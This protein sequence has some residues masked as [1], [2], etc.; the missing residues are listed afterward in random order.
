[1]NTSTATQ[2][3][4]DSEH[5]VLTYVRVQD[6][7]DL[8]A[9]KC[10]PMRMKMKTPLAKALDAMSCIPFV[11]ISYDTS[12]DSEDTL[13]IAGVE[14]GNLYNP[15][16]DVILEKSIP[17][18]F[19]KGS[20]TVLNPSYSSEREIH[21]E[22]IGFNASV[23]IVRRLLE[24]VKPLMFP[25]REIDVKLDKLAVYE[26]GGHFDWHMDSTHSDK[27]HATLLVVLNMTWDGGDLVLKRTWICNL[28][29]L[30]P[31]G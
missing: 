12:E 21:R 4:T 5:E 27:H 18:S 30:I 19:G 20:E 8:I 9:A 6:R 13:T 17:S 15:K 31:V 1:M 14:A 24:D 28:E 26:A 11:Q 16:V 10:N 2:C 3:D 22:D 29:T 23:G 25:G 7:M